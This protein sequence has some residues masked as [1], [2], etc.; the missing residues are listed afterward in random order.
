MFSLVL[1]EFAIKIS[2]FAANKLVLSQSFTNTKSLA[3]TKSALNVI[4]GLDKNVFLNNVFLQMISAVRDKIALAT[5][6]T[7]T[8]YAV[9]LHMEGHFWREHVLLAAE[10]TDGGHQIAGT[11][12]ASFFVSQWHLVVLLVAH[13]ALDANEGWQFCEK[14]FFFSN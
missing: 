6:D 9:A 4:L 11:I 1:A 5:L 12:F 3:T 7:S 13:H 8:E 10:L 2:H 14:Q